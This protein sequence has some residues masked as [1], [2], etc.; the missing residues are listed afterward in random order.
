MRIGSVSA[1]AGRQM[2]V[3]SA[4]AL[5]ADPANAWRRLI[6]ILISSWVFPRIALPLIL[7]NWHAPHAGAAL[8]LYR[9][10]LEIG[11]SHLASMRPEALLHW[12]RAH[13]ISDRRRIGGRAGEDCASVGLAA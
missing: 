3:A 13:S 12:A 10:I 4:A 7:G 11:E 9:C 6:R 1:I 2:P 8:E 5:A